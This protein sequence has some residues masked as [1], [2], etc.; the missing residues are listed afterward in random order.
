MATKLNNVIR[1]CIELNTN[2]P[3]LSIHDQG[4]GG[5]AIV[6]KEIIYPLGGEINLNNVT[7]GDNTMTSVEIWCSE[8]QESDVLLID[9]DNIKLLQKLCIRENICCDILGKIKNTNKIE[10]IYNNEIIPATIKRNIRNN[11]QKSFFMSNNYKSIIKVNQNFNL[12]EI[13]LTYDSLMHYISYV[14]ADIDVC[15]KRFL[16]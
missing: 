14:L 11:I 13:S 9:K 4:S 8:F 1:S 7:L 10:V 6:V 2:N 15:S 16:T 3:I 5:L 12:T